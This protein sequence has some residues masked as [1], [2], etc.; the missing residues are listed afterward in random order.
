MTGYGAPYPD[1]RPATFIYQ[2]VVDQDDH[3]DPVDGPETRTTVDGCVW[4]PLV[5]DETTDPGRA[6]VILGLT[7]QCPAD[8]DVTHL[9]HVEL[10]GDD[11]PWQVDGE[12]GTWWSPLSGETPGIQ[13]TLKR[14]EG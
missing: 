9:H 12:P 2:G 10:D 13:L 6:G 1:G 14:S 11:R 4:Y 3:G 5:G 8:V 7:L